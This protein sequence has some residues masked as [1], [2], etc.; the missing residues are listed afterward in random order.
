MKKKFDDVK[1]EIIQLDFRDDI[2]TASVEGHELDGDNLI[3]IDGD[4]LGW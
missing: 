3:P 1:L 2:L 4:S